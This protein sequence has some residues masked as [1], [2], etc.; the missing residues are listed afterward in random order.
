MK[1]NI[2]GK[3]NE[4]N[5]I[6]KILKE[7]GLNK[8]WVNAGK[9]CLLDGSVMRNFQEGVE[10]LKKHKN[11]KVWIL[12]DSDVDGITS[13]AIL[14]LWLER[15]FSNMELNYII[16]EGK[17]HGILD[18]LM[19]KKEDCD[20]FIIPDA[21]SSEI[22]KHEKYSKLYDILVLDHHEFMD[23]ALENPYAVVINPKHPL[24]SYSNK[25]LS[26]AGVV[27]KF[28][29]AFDKLD[30]IDKHSDLIDLAAIGMI[31]DVMDFTHLENKAIANIGL[32]NLKNPFVLA[33]MSAEARMKNKELLTPT[34]VSF[35]LAPLINGVIRIGS[36]QDKID[37]FEAVIGKQRPELV[38]VDLIKIKGR[39]D[40]Q[41]DPVV[42]RIVFNM[43]KNKT[44]NNSII[45][46]T[47][48]STMPRT[49]TGLI[50]GQLAGM[51]QKPAILGRV[52]DE[53]DF[54]GSLRSLNGSS[55]ENFKDFCEE[56]GLF[57]WV[58]G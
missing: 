1:I 34:N 20:L 44:D 11:D 42:T 17:V 2:L 18:P 32:N 41:K 43:Q 57:N 6:E 29:E 30:E 24:C 22:D 36:V 3:I 58:A 46:A 21:S 51:Y 16:P 55:V 38:I 50:A 19:P 12:V 45:F 52:N 48:P 25:N 40:R 28:I 54:V 4:N 53:G 27:Y 26:G 15:T 8:E 14:Y 23:T 9:E 31:A 5:A 33:Y 37:L 47:A 39:H 7:A 56:S 35:Y 13:S 10:L 49:M